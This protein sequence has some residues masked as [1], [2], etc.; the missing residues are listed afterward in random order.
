MPHP[1]SLSE[2]T[3]YSLSFHSECPTCETR[4]THD[5]GSGVWV[6]PYC[7]RLAIDYETVDGRPVLN[8]GLANDESV[9][10]IK[11]LGGFATQDGLKAM[12]GT[13]YA[14]KDDLPDFACETTDR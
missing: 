14:A 9:R 13:P 8:Y 11:V 5:A 10:T 3:R 2:T 12:F 1:D 6:C 4:S 7:G